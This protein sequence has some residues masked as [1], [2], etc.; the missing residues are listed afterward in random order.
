MPHRGTSVPRSRSC[1]DVSVDLGK[2]RYFAAGSTLASS[3]G[4]S[5][6]GKGMLKK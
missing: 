3:A 1:N 4:I 5:L 6:T 2:A